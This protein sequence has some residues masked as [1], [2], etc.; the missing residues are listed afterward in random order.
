M[1]NTL[2][3]AA[4]AI[5]FGATASCGSPPKATSYIATENS[6]CPEGFEA[7]PDDACFALPEQRGEKTAV[8][9][10]MHDAYKG[11]GP[12]A[13][14]DLVKHATEKGFAVVLVRGRRD[15]CGL[16]GA[17]SDRD[18]CWPQ[19]PDD[20]ATMKQLVLSW[21]KTIWQADALLESG[22]HRRY[23]LGYGAGGAF[24][25]TLATQGF[26]EAS[27]YGM[28]G[29]GASMPT[30]SPGKKPVL[31]VT[32][33][34]EAD[35]EAPKTLNEALDKANW[36]H[37][38][39]ARTQKELTREDVE[40]VL[41]DFVRDRNGELASFIAAGPKSGD[42]CDPPVATASPTPKKK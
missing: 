13:E 19:D 7:G 30:P 34:G 32:V 39:C 17:P 22:P 31:V 26:L 15:L 35:G 1:R 16:T 41:K 24:A 42:P 5:V 20:T 10:Y 11:K 28:I 40:M 36:G 14:W 18:F 33:S 2:A 27:G 8:L 21:D 6:W 37:A 12:T 25:G 4:C 9:I 38:K 3:V 23:V 29:A